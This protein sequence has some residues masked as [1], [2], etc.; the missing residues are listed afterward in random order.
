MTWRA[1]L[2]LGAGALTLPAWPAPFV[3]VAAMTGLVL[4]L[5]ALDWALAAPLHRLSA[6]RDGDR[7][8]RLGGTATVTLHLANGSARTLRAQVRDAWVPSAG[9]RP[10][11]PQGRVLRVEPGGSATL[12]VRL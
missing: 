2:L 7:P 9:A 5:V 11:V 12:P 4:L 6:T 8:V 10:D 3:G 1:A